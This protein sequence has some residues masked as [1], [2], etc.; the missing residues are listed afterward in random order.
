MLSAE[1]VW[2]LNPQACKLVGF[3]QCLALHTFIAWLDILGI[4]HS[5]H[6]G[7]NSYVMCSASQHLKE[8]IC[9]PHKEVATVGSELSTWCGMGIV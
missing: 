6:I 4:K 1:H 5:Q 8:S 3:W 2:F 7:R 9:Y